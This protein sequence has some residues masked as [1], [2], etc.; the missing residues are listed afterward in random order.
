MV[1]MNNEIEFIKTSDFTLAATL[2]CMGHVVTGIDKE[3]PKRA[4]F[5]FKKTVVVD[6]CV[7]KYFANEL[8]VNPLDFARAQREIRAQMHTD[9]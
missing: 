1:T 4:I 5:Y 3:N 2:L 6:S 8:L 9:L 7:R